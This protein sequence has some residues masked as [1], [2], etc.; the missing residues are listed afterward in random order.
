M[1]LVPSLGEPELYRGA[2][3]HPCHLGQVALGPRGGLLFGRKNID[4]VEEGRNWG[5]VTGAWLPGL[6]D[7]QTLLRRSWSDRNIYMH[8]IVHLLFGC[9]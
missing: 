6:M 8:H 1:I 5:I 9:G 4:R 7:T 3:A 2:T